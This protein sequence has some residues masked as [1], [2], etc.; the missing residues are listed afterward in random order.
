MQNLSDEPLCA[1]AWSPRNFAKLPGQQTFSLDQR[2]RLETPGWEVLDYEQNAMSP[3]EVERQR[4]KI[5]RAPLVVRDRE[6]PFLEDVIVE[7]TG[8]VDPYLGV[9]A[10]VSSLIEVLHLGGCHELVYQLWAQFNLCAV[11]DNVDAMWSGDEVLVSIY[12]RPWC[13]HS[14]CASSVFVL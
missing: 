1:D 12:I 13:L 10:K 5:T 14:L 9:M 6:Y 11:P 2:L 8:A 3:A 4:E 7:E